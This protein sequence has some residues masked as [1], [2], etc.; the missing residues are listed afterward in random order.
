MDVRRVATG[1]DDQGRAVFVSDETV[2]GVTL[3]LL[4]GWEFHRLW[5]SDVRPAF[6]DAGN[7]PDSQLYFPPPEGFRFAI[8]T[9][10]PGDASGVPEDLDLEAAIAEFQER[11][12]GMAEHLEVEHPGMHT[13]ASVDVGV[14]LSGEAT[15]ELDDGARVVLRA[16]DTYVQNGTRHRWSNKG[17]VPAIIA[18]ALIGAHHDNVG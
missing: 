5:G 1:H 15:L 10:P 8:F 9:I 14:V 13:T 11:L 12:P 7:R 16:G 18:L 6:P 2:S 3:G 17:S 4:P